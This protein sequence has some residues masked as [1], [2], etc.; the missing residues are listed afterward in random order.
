MEA[1]IEQ[2]LGDVVTSD[3]P[4]A[5]ASPRHSLYR[6]TRQTDDGAS[7]CQDRADRQLRRALAF[8]GLKPLDLHEVG[9]DADSERP[10]S[11]G[12]VSPGLLRALEL[13]LSPSPR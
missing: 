5:P 11:P 6:T 10:P 8:A 2:W 13:I 3:Q 1:R 7:G 9:T 12:T 4:P